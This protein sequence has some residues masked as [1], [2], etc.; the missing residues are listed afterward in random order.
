LVSWRSPTK[1][2]SNDDND[3]DTDDDDNKDDNNDQQPSSITPIDVD[4][5][6]I[7][8]A[9]RRCISAT[10]KEYSIPPSLHRTAFAEL[11]RATTTL[12]WLPVVRVV[13][14]VVDNGQIAS[15]RT[16]YVSGLSRSRRRKTLSQVLFRPKWCIDWST[17]T[18]IDDWFYC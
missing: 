8:R 15:S 18:I 4:N 1:Q 12:L 17:T 11:T 9:R 2:T 6:A 10:L 16:I 13:V 7:E 14:D 5:S 3:N